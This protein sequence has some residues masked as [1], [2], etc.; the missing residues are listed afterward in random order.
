[1]ERSHVLFILQSQWQWQLCN[2]PG[3]NAFIIPFIPYQLSREDR[4]YPLFKDKGHRLKKLS[5]ITSGSKHGALELNP[6]ALLSDAQAQVLNRCT[7]LPPGRLLCMHGS[8]ERF[9]RGDADGHFISR[10]RE[11][12][13]EFFPSCLYLKYFLILIT[14]EMESDKALHLM[15]HH[16]F[17]VS[18][19]LYHWLALTWTSY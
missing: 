19:Q 3:F 14:I 11:E 9:W 12:S 13:R 17:W 4:Y 16:Q 8:L 18:A 7:T 6:R 1:M 15:L 2:V 10:G 5:K